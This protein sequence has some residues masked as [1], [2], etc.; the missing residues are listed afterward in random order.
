MTDWSGGSLL[1]LRTAGDQADTAAKLKIGPK[2]VGQRREPISDAQ[3]E[4]DVHDSPQPPCGCAPD[5]FKMPKSA[6]AVTC[7]RRWWQERSQVA[8]TK[9]RHW[10]TRFR[11]SPEFAL[12]RQSSALL[13]AAGA[14]PGTISP[15]QA[16]LAC[17]GVADREYIGEPRYPQVI[18]HDEASRPI[19]GRAVQPRR[20][21]RCSHA[22][23]PSDGTRFD[24]S[25]V[26]G[27]PRFIDM[28]NPAAETKFP[29]PAASSERCAICASRS[30]KLGSNRG[31][32]WTE[33]HAG[34]RRIERSGKSPL[35]QSKTGQF[36]AIR[37]QASSTPVGPP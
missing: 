2:P 5:S 14:N 17:L 6:T 4:G 16:L 26:N 29:L 13:L 9:C 11:P 28:I 33:N 36:S 25:S 15:F 37:A 23:G 30:G 8:I 19:G 24:A 3:H 21:R 31:A 7:R 27:N 34:L 18:A 10:V 12:P 22:G 35:L 20:C 1:R 32:A